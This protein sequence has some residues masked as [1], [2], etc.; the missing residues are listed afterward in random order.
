MSILKAR[1][2]HMLSWG[3]D[4]FEDEILLATLTLKWLRE[5]G[6]FQWN[7]AQFHLGREGFWSGDFLLTR[8]DQAM[9]RAKK[10]SPFTRTFRLEI[11]GQSMILSAR[12]PFGRT[13][14]LTQHGTIVG[15]IRPNHLLTRACVLDLPDSMDTPNWVFIFWLV[16]LMWRRTSRSND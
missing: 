3:F 2:R 14:Q 12:S 8:N 7:D 5:G 10:T 4:L 11:R 16:V 1:P 9:A 13:F 6:T 15:T